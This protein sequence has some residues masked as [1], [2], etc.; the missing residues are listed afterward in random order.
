MT[1]IYHT[2]STVSVVQQG[3][4]TVKV[5]HLGRRGEKGDPGFASDSRS[6][7][8]A[9]FD[10]NTECAVGDGVAFVVPAE[11]A[12]MTLTAVTVSVTGPTAGIGGSMTVQSVRRRVGVDANML[13]SVVTID[14]AV[15]SSAASTSTIVVDTDY[16][17]LAEGDVIFPR[18]VTV[19]TTPAA[20]LT[21][22]F[23][24]SA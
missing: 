13:S 3:P 6:W 4:V 17:D 7:S 10:A 21:V 5:E 15:F 14:S 20:G 8:V 16:D 2:T 22:T 9:V 11:L 19:H 1:K 18:V 24:V 23:T 12:G